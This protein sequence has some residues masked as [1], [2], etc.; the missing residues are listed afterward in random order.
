MIFDK[1]LND[2]Y[3][4]ILYS[5][6]NLDYLKSIDSNNF[7]EIYNLLKNKGF[8][9]IDDIII[10]YMDMFELDKECLNKVLTYLEDKMGK[11]YIKKI[12][13]NM[14]ILDKI[15]G[16]TINLEMK[17]DQQVTK[18]LKTNDIIKNELSNYSNDVTSLVYPESIIL[19]S[20]DG[21]SYPI[22]TKEK[23]L[24]DKLYTLKPLKNYR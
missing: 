13:L 2:T 11:D 17:E 19:K 6:Y 21:Y 8:Y 15:I 16:T 24:C 20:E 3:L 5:N 14:T 9:F 7:I 12:G 1:Y 10:N 23:A 18:L 4:D 22:A